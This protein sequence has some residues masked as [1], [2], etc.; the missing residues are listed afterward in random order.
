[1]RL[2]LGLARQ[3]GA[4]ASDI[5]DGVPAE[6]GADLARLYAETAPFDFPMVVR[7]QVA[8]GGADGRV[9]AY[10]Y[11]LSFQKATLFIYV[12]GADGFVD[13]AT[14]LPQQDTAGAPARR[15]SPA[16]TEVAVLAADLQD[17]ARLWAELPTEEYFELVNEVWMTVEPILRRHKGTNGKHPGEGLVCYFLPQPDSSH[18]WN[19]LT[20]AHQ[21]REAMRRISREWRLRK[22]WS[23]ELFL[24]TGIDEGQEWRGQLRPGS[25]SGFTVL[26]NSVNRALRISGFARDGAVWVTKNLV[27]RLGATDL[28]RLKFGVRRTTENGETVLV[29]STFS[30]VESLRGVHLQANDA[31]API[32]QV[33]ITEVIDIAAGMGPSDRA[34]GRNPA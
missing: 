12:P 14:L 11:A 13:V 2:H 29:A 5:C 4:E 22:G 23:S 24:N 20:A 8:S 3:R 21:V 10:L 31:L 6:Q 26:G 32:A 30:S 33:P 1:M 9:P 34:A 16:L 25:D 19:A 7:A 17:A 18:L 28:R 27:A 15:P